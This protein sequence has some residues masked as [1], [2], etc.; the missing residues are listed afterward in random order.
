MRVLLLMNCN[1][2]LYNFRNELVDMI[3]THNSELIIS[4]PKGKYDD[5]YRKKG[6]ILIDSPIE[7]RGVNLIN[8]L[9]LSKYYANLIKQYK[10]DI[11]LTFTAKPNI[12]GN[13][14]ARKFGVKTI[15][16]ITGLGFGFHKM[17][18]SKI[19]KILYYVSIKKANFLFLQNEG[20]MMKLKKLHLLPKDYKVIS[21]SGVNTTIFCY[22]KYPTHNV[23]KFLYMAR[24]IKEKGIDEYLYTAKCMKEKYGDKVEFLVA[25]FYDEEKY[26]NI[27][28][29]YENYNIITYCGYIED[30]VKLYEDIN[31]IVVPSY[32]EGMSNVLLEAGSTGRATIASEIHGCKEIILDAES[33]YLF[34]LKNKEDCLNKVELYY[35]LTNSEKKEMGKRASEFIKKNFDRSII[36]KE[37]EDKIFNDNNK[38]EGF[39]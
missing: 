37:Y 7:R 31:C 19:M 33:G 6:C 5:F 29:E 25:G 21:G 9:K 8:D 39:K 28:E 26:K 12:Y 17:I 16:N 34:E 2:S 35:N 24:V 10:P 22:K 32:S 38:N 13:I 4:V 14:A 30:K 3:L 23:I 11:V 36:V 27:I 15:S 20:D 18:I 1:V